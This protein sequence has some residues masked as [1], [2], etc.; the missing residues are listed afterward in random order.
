MDIAEVWEIC[1]KFMWDQS[2]VD[3]LNNFLTKN[4]V[5]KILDCGGGTGFPSIPLKKHEWDISYC[6]NNPIMVRHFQK[7]LQKQN[8]K[9][10]TYTSSWVDLS[11]NIK[12]NFDAILCRGNSLIYVNSWD[13]NKPELNKENIKKTLQEFHKKLNEN[14]LLYIDLINKKEFHREKYPILEEIGEKIID[15]K[16]IKITWELFHDYDKKIRKCNIIMKVDDKTEIT[17]LYS[18][19]L[20]HSKLINLMK[21][22]GFKDV[23]EVNI[24]GEENYNVIVGYK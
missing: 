4:K 2:Y 3:G 11:K 16:K 18:Y 19:L 9:I 12:E 10:P 5:K 15:G 20:E 17:T 13:I 1:I 21:E 22:I 24:D 14:G 23:K 7:E 8:L 6:D